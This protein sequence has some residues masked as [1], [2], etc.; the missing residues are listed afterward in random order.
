MVSLHFLGRILYFRKSY[1]VLDTP[2]GPSK[3]FQRH[4]YQLMNSKEVTVIHYIGDEQLASS[5]GH[6]QFSMLHT[7][8]QARPGNEANEHSV[9]NFPHRNAKVSSP[10]CV[11][12]LTSNRQCAAKCKVNKSNM[13]YKLEG[14]GPDQ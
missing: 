14:G 6:S 9:T 5:P 10:L 3:S 11:H 2:N 4:T 8:K 7:E 13:V 1:F 12:V